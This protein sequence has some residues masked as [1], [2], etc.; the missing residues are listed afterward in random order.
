[1]PIYYIRLPED[2][3]KKAL[4]SNL[5][6]TLEKLNSIEVFDAIGVV[7]APGAADGDLMS[8]LARDVIP[9]RIDMTPKVGDTMFGDPDVRHYLK[10]G[11][12][13]GLEKSEEIDHQGI[14]CGE[15]GTLFVPRRKDS[16][17]C[18]TRCYQKAYMRDHGNKPRKNGEISGVKNGKM[19][20]H[21][22]G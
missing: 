2:G 15:C 8:S 6:G 19:V 16:R 11:D 5:V 13:T 14:P 4:I 20:G 17:Y 7:L 3:E 12:A 9:E 21:H 10:T 18:S 22:A 1:M